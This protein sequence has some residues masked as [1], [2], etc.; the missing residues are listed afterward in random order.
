MELIIADIQ[1]RPNQYHA[2][3][4]PGMPII[5]TPLYSL[6]YIIDYRQCT[7][8]QVY[9]TCLTFRRTRCIAEYCF[10]VFLSI[11]LEKCLNNK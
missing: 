7:V 9:S 1:Y 6:C 3:V 8:K 11:R 10:F 4:T 5:H 2:E